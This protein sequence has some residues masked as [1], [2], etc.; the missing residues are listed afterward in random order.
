MHQKEG[1]AK[2]VVVELNYPMDLICMDFLS[3]EMSA[4]G[5]GHLLVN[6]ISSGYPNQE[7]VNQNHSQVLI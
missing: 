6:Q 4:G 2:L 1:S 3:L 5:Y 7:S